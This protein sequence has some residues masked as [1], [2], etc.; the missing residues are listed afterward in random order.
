M[1]M[2]KVLKGLV[3]V[4]FNL[5][6]L[7]LLWNAGWKLILTFCV[8]LFVG[9]CVVLYWGFSRNAWLSTIFR[10]VMGDPAKNKK[11]GKRSDN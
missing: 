2:K 10:E 6:I 8:G 4:C 9:A 3:L 11:S 1:S 5:G 7:I